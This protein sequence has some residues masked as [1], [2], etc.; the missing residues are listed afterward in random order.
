MAWLD[1]W[2][3][4]F[5]VGGEADGKVKLLDPAMATQ[6]AGVALWKEKR[7]ED[8]V[9]PLAAGLARWG[10]QE[11]THHDLLGRRLAAFGVVPASP[12]ATLSDY[13]LAAR[14]AQPR[15]QLLRR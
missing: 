3:R 14:D 10:W 11:S 4:R 7:R 6:G 9:L 2:F 13:A 1:F 8:R 5:R 15:S 12:R